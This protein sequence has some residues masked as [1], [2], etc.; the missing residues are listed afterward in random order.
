MVILLLLLL[1]YSL[2][3]ALRFLC[4]SSNTLVGCSCISLLDTPQS[5]CHQNRTLQVKD[6]FCAILVLL[7]FIVIMFTL[8]LMG[9]YLAFAVLELSSSLT[10]GASLSWN[11]HLL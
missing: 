10:L 4:K 6:P 7:G 3:E 8:L 1:L 2:R 5:L 9:R 11:H